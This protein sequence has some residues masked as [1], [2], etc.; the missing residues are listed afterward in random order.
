M[1]SYFQRSTLDKSK[2]KP[3]YFFSSFITEHHR[4]LSSFYDNL[5]T[6]VSKLFDS[7]LAQLTKLLCKSRSNATTT[8]ALLAITQQV[9]T[10]AAYK[11]CC[12]VAFN[13]NFCWIYGGMR[14]K[15][16]F[17]AKIIRTIDAGGIND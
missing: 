12:D 2:T 8:S 9:L 11:V 1:F 14:D 5:A 6:C 17:R 3:I 16:V 7:F 13:C 4:H 10:M 15:F